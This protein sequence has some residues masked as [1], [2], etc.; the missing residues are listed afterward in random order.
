MYRLH[1]HIATFHLEHGSMA[2]VEGDVGRRE[3]SCFEEGLVR[4]H[5]NR[6]SL[7]SNT[8]AMFPCEFN[9]C[10]LQIQS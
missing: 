1:E 8:T 6:D 5:L 3:G 2:K 7:H 9:E 10:K 4:L